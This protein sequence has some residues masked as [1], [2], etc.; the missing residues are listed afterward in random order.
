MRRKYLGDSYDLVKR[1]FAGALGPIAPLYAHPQFVPADIRADYTVITAI[2]ILG[3]RPAG[4]FGLLLDPHTGVP[5]PTARTQRPTPSYAPVGFIA[6]LAEE[7]RPTYLICFDQSYHRRPGFGS[8]AQR[9]AKRRALEE[10][11]I[12]SF[13]YVS[14]AP[15]LFAATVSDILLEVRGRLRDLGIPESRLESSD[16]PAI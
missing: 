13:H 3:S 12:C 15:F 10:R 4:E 16:D 5:L 1:T 8:A 7:L 14:H 9:E 2:P 11:K 6:S